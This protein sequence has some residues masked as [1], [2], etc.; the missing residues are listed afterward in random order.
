MAVYLFLLHRLLGNCEAWGP[1]HLP[2]CLASLWWWSCCMLVQWRSVSKE[3]RQNAIY[4]VKV[5]L[6]ERACEATRMSTPWRILQVQTPTL[7]LLSTVT[8][9][10]I[11]MTQM[12]VIRTMTMV[13]DQS[14]TATT[15]SI[16]A[17]HPLTASSSKWLMNLC[18]WW[19]V[20][21]CNEHTG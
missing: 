18:A 8:K 16:F 14:L 1:Y 13:Q 5:V 12:R 6:V 21:C 3:Q 17:F 15:I 19:C 20:A 11:M 10:I 9:P 4:W 7:L 2:S